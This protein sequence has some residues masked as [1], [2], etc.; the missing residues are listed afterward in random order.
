VTRITRALNHRDQNGIPQVA[1]YQRG[2]GTDSD[3]E[4][5]L[6]GGLSGDDIS[7]HIREAYAFLANNFDPETQEDVDDPTKPMDEIVLLGFSRGAYTARAIATLI[8]DIGLLTKKG[9]EDFWGI[10]GDWMKQDV[11]GNESEWFKSAYGKVVPFTD[12]EYRGTLMKV[13]SNLY[14]KPQL[15]LQPCYQC[16]LDTRAFKCGPL[17]TINTLDLTHETMT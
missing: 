8:T 10:F 7:E 11:K 2:V 17:S 14:S 13:S 6:V 15:L 1:F 3:A 4:D 12:P 9:M 16:P 5:K